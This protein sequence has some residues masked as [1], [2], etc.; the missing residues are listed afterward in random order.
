MKAPESHPISVVAIFSARF[1]F[2][3]DEREGR[4]CDLDNQLLGVIEAGSGFVKEQ[5][6]VDLQ[7]LTFSK[8][9]ARAIGDLPF[10]SLVRKLLQ[11]EC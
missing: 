11:L 3:G 10:F 9:N 6:C 1:E 7:S 8:E 5:A 2:H 4:R